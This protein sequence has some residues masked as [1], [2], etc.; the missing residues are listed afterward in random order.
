MAPPY[1]DPAPWPGEQVVCGPHWPDGATSRRTPAGEY[2]VA[3]ILRSLPKPP[4]LF[5]AYVDSYGRAV[6]RNLAALACPKLLLVGDTHHGERPIAKLVA[7]A[8]AER[9][10]LIAVVPNRQSCHW[11]TEAGLGPVVYCGPSVLVRPYAGEIQRQRYPVV[12]F[13]G[14]G[15]VHHLRRRRLLEAMAAKG[16]AVHAGDATQDM[17]LRKFAKCQIAF[18]CSL[19]GDANMRVFEI[20]S[21]GGC[22]FSDRLNPD[23]GLEGDLPDGV[24]AIWYDDDAHCLELAA[25]WLVRPERCL[26]IGLAGRDAFLAGHAP[27]VKMAQVLDALFKGVVHPSLAPPPVV[28]AGRLEERLS[29]YEVLQEMHRRTERLEVR[30]DGAGMAP[31]ALDAADLMRLSPVLSEP[32]GLPAGWRAGRIRSG[33]AGPGAVTVSAGADGRAGVRQPSSA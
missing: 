29:V 21:A 8:R 32:A 28:P 6:P 25:H 9:Y 31:F 14:Q 11:F 4:D 13:A 24:R 2:D 30:F 10:D 33:A 7:H 1:I 20:L 23:A 18:N 26:E 15:G 17:A 3:P 22:L 12:G 27:A 5:I 19:N 16:L